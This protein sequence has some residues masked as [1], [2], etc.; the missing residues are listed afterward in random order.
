MN[1]VFCTPQ[2][3]KEKENK[4]EKKSR[5]LVSPNAVFVVKSNLSMS[6]GIWLQHSDLLC[7]KKYVFLTSWP[8][9]VHVLL[10]FGVH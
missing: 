9:L 7:V 2:C 10:V 3:S 5:F 1:L 8:H 4:R 6:N